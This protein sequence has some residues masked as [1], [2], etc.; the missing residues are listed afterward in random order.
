VARA[1]T[2][3]AQLRLDYQ[4]VLDDERNIPLW[5]DETLRK[6]LH[7]NPAKRYDTLSEFIHDLR[8]PN[9]QFLRNHRPPLMESNPLLFWKGLSLLL[10]I[11]VLY[12]LAQRGGF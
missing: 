11:A 1:S 5:V 10:F 8:Q 4:S 9:P 6:A 12:L 7:P 3:A 2:R